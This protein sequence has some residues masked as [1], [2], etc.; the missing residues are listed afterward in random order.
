M[1]TTGRAEM[2][3]IVPRRLQ[4][5]AGIKK[6]DQLKFDVTRHAITITVVRL[7]HQS[8]RRFL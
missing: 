7:L 4:K 3:L 6:G 8:P 5:R 1:T 2:P